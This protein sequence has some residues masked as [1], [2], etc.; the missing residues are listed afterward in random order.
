MIDTF[1]RYNG[2]CNFVSSIAFE[3]KLSNR[4]FLQKV[5]YKDIRETFDLA[6][7]LTI[8]VIGKTDRNHYHEF[9]DY[10]SIVYDQ[11]ILSFKGLDKVSINTTGG[12][13]RIPKT[14]RKYV[15]IPLKG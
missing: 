15:Q 4:V 14:I 7:Q 11:R 6:S 2:A 1:L 12:S 8:R 3:K 10:G 9:M 13:I 5:V